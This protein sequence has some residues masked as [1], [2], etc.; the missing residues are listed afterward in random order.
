MATV[1]HCLYCFETLS[2][3]LEKRTPM[4]LYQVQASWA[5]YP[6][7]LELEEGEESAAEEDD[8]EDDDSES[9]PATSKSKRPSIRNPTLDRLSSARSNGSGTS[10]PASSSSSS[11]EPS[12]A[13]T[14]PGS[15]YKLPPTRSPPQCISTKSFY[16]Q[17]F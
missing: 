3:S 4:T 2:A 17:E 1:E 7:S 11:L 12:T 15:E 14:T 8:S 5:D 13:A 6:Q 16:A 9:V 10:T